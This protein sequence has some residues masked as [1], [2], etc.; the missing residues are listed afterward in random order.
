MATKTATATKKQNKTE[1]SKQFSAKKIGAN[2]IASYDG[3]KV[4]SRKVSKEEY[5]VIARKMAFYNKK[6]S[7]TGYKAIIKLL[8]PETSKK[9]AE[10][11]ATEAK[12]KGY[13]KL[14]KK[15]DKKAKADKKEDVKRDIME[16][17]EEMLEVDKSSV[18]KVQ[19]LLDK[20]KEVPVPEKVE[21]AKRYGGEY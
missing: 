12:V 15:E 19:S 5:D 16:E 13:K 14:Q 4:G 2:I 20:F 1:T 21:S 10:K 7:D 8:A 17:L 11:E 18:S 6:P 3:K 9:A